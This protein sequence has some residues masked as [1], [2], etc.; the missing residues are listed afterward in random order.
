VEKGD[1]LVVK[2]KS[3]PEEAQGTASRVE[4]KSHCSTNVQES[5]KTDVHS[6]CHWWLEMKC[7]KHVTN[8]QQLAQRN[9]QGQDQPSA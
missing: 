5:E 1:I 3:Q 7:S 8:A 6:D 4:L 9:K 2:G